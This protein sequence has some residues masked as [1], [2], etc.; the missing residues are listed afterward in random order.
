[1][2]RLSGAPRL[3]VLA[4][5]SGTLLEAMIAQNLPIALV[6]A[7]RQCRALEIARRAGVSAVLIDRR[8]FG[9][10]S[11][12]D[13]DRERF[14]TA[15]AGQLQRSG[16]GVIAMAGF[17]TVFTP[18]IFAKFPDRILNTHPA[19]LPDFKGATAVA[20]ALA[21]GI[22]E[23]GCTIHFAAPELDSGTIIAQAE[24]PVRPGDTV[25]TLWER[26]KTAERRLYPAVLR[27]FLQ[28]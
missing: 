28:T 23:T 8:R 16:A 20:D 3:A 25:G 4:S 21:A 1:M 15:V 18:S 2:A 26:I 27:Q 13:W 19:L 9:Y 5:G 7:D 6:L 10:R 22:S 24:V 17:M 11:G 12:A 14:T